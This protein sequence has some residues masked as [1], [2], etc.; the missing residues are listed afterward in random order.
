MGDFPAQGQGGGL[1]IIPGKPLPNPVPV[2]G[3]TFVI[4]NLKRGSQGDPEVGQRGRTHRQRI[5][6]TTGFETDGKSVDDCPQPPGRSIAEF[7]LR[8][9]FEPTLGPA[10]GGLRKGTLCGAGSANS[11]LALI[12]EF[13]YF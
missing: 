2:V 8:P 12:M 5:G 10:D 9:Q 7:Q 1:A 4:W 11:R 3:K 6:V 13:F